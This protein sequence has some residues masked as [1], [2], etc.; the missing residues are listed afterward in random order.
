[1]PKRPQKKA[2][3]SGEPEIPADHPD[4]KP[5]PGKAGLQAI[6]TIEKHQTKV[7]VGTLAAALLICGGLVIRE[8]SAHKRTVAAEAYT[9]AA[10]ARSIEQLDTV[11]AK[12]SGSI[13]AGN[14]LLS[15]AEIQLSQEKTEDARITLLAFTD[16][17]RKHPRYA[18]GLFAIGN[19]QHNA[20][21][22]AE[23]ADYYD[24]A[25]AAT[26]DADIAPL[27]LIRKGDLIMAEADKL[28]AEGNKEE[29]E[30]K[31]NEART[32][33]EDSG[34][35]YP[36]NPFVPLAAEKIDILAIGVVPVVDPPPPA[37]EP[38]P[39]PEPKV[40]P[41]K[42]IVPGAGAPKADAPKPVAPKADAPKP[43]A[44]KADAPKPVAPKA[45]APKPVAP[46]ADAPKPV[47][48]K[49]DAPKPVA[50]KADAPKADAPKPKPPVPGSDKAPTPN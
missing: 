20:G 48:P 43:V 38:A 24:R 14:A 31:K 37:P 6:D 19:I 50:P 2:K 41:D 12:Y 49:A 9:Q 7:I 30:A 25:L 13:A 35:R 8:Y 44:P 23:A 39:V 22:A 3:Q 17:Y 34:R 10:S 47:A 27:V 16:K 5:E 18:Q 21:N 36:A 46:K 4:A 45:T 29:A 26:P 33:Y 15:K 11:V 28:L 1:M 42:P 40:V 32:L